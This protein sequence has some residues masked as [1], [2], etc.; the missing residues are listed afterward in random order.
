[1]R[2][3]IL[4]GT[5]SFISVFAIAKHHE[6]TQDFPFKYFLQNDIYTENPQMFV[7]TVAD[8]VG[9]GVLDS[10]GVALGLYQYNAVG[11][12]GASHVMM[13]SYPDADSLPSPT[14]MTTS[15][16]HVAFTQGMSKAGNTPVQSTLYRSVK[17]VIPA[18]GNTEDIKVFMNYF[19]KVSDADTYAK[20][21]LDLMK[22]NGSTAYGLRE[23]I[24]GDTDGVTHMIWMGYGSMAE[25]VK[26]QE[27]LYASEATQNALI[28]FAKIR[29][30]KRTA[31]L[32]VAVE[33]ITETI[34]N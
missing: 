11:R 12:F 23:V 7:S 33:S 26:E 3:L 2:K 28:E 25:L 30:I 17:E 1:M 21:W 16:A 15:K 4:L 27:R 8:F 5:L 14:L 31:V 34:S 24:S 32:T 13:F 29:E 10:R 9:S 20:I 22:K 18:D 6:Q 19:V